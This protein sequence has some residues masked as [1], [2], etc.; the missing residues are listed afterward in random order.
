MTRAGWMAYLQQT[1]S[2]VY[3]LAG[4]F[5]LYLNWRTLH[6]ESVTVV[7][8]LFILYAAYRFFMIR[9]WLRRQS[10]LRKEEDSP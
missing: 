8:V 5:L 3:L 7:G 6:R 1:T 10:S 2:V 9:R 4:I